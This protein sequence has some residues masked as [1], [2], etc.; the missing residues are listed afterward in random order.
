MFTEEERAWLAQATTTMQIIVGALAS[1]VLLFLGV[2][3]LI[4]RQA[5]GPPADEPLLTYLSVAL[6]AGSIV[7]AL[8]VPGILI[9]RQRNAI[10][11][12]KA[13]FQIGS[14]GGAPLPEA[15]RTLGP[16]VASYQTARILRSAILEGAA[17]FC[18]LAYLIERR[19][20]ALVAAGVLVLVL[21]RACF[22]N[23][24]WWL[25]SRL[26]MSAIMVRWIIASPCSGFRS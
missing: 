3:L 13:K 21:L 12:G 8:V 15:D 23:Q 6:A 25:A 9:R 5:G 1:G 26:D 18:L 20:P 4:T 2:A 14:I 22:K 24:D 17:F 19:T 7:A 10:L 16:F 11:A